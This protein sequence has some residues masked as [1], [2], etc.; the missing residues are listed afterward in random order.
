MSAMIATSMMASQQGNHSMKEELEV[1]PREPIY[2]QPKPPKGAKDYF[3][4][5]KG[6]FSTER[7]LKTECVFK[8]FARDDKNAKRKFNN[9]L[10]R[11]K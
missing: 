8:C 3:F 9:W 7:M 11:Q 4:N 2:R 10:K 1:D 6:E 5:E